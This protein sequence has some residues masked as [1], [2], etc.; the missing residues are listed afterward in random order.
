MEDTIVTL[1]YTEL[2]RARRALHELK[3]LDR[4]RRLQVRGAALVQR[5]GRGGMDAPPGRPG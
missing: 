4:E 1:R 5:S 3:R 2:G